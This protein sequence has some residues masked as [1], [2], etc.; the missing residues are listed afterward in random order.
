MGIIHLYTLR[1][2]YKIN[3]SIAIWSQ[4][5]LSLFVG[6]TILFITNKTPYDQRFQ[7]RGVQSISQDILLLTISPYEWR[8]MGQEM[9]F[10]NLSLSEWQPELWN[11]VLDKLSKGRPDSIGITFS[12]MNEKTSL[13]PLKLKNYENV[14]WSSY[15]H[16][17]K[18]IYPYFLISRK[19]N[20]GVSYLYQG[21]DGVIRSH[22]FPRG[23]ITFLEKVAGIKV[24]RDNES[25]FINFRGKNRKFERFS[26]SDFFE[27]GYPNELLKN[28]YILIGHNE[29]HDQIFLTPT[30]RMPKLELLANVLDNII[31]KR[32]INRLSLDLSIAYLIVLLIG[33][34][35]LMFTGLSSLT[36]ALLFGGLGAVVIGISTWAFNSF[37]LWIPIFAPLCLLTVTYMIFLIFQLSSKKA[38]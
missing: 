11:K 35:W 36:L 20:L 14:Y 13:N 27:K 8:T 31:E 6:I 28:K 1:L 10:T 32:W 4:S 12:F 23:K 2:L 17:G 30:G 21:H 3:S 5:L 19:K 15:E 18:I 29:D 34:T 26:L 24:H 22:G 37:Y 16:E 9:G 38:L 25:L 33:A 7:I